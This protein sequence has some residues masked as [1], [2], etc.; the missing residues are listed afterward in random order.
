MPIADVV[1]RLPSVDRLTFTGA[2]G[3]AWFDD[4]CRGTYDVE[5]AHVAYQPYR[6]SLV[7]ES[8]D[9]DL[10]VSL[11]P[12]WYEVEQV[13]V[14]ADA[15]I[16]QVSV[17]R[18]GISVPRATLEEFSSMDMTDAVALLPGVTVAGNRPFYRGVGFEQVQP[19]VDGVPARVPLTGEWILP[20]PQALGSAELLS[21]AMIAD[22]PASLGGVLAFRL[23]EGGPEPRARLTVGADGVGQ[24][25]EGNRRADFGS[26]AASGPAGLAGLTYS[27]AWQG[28]V[29]NGPHS[30]DIGSPTQNAFGFIPLG[31]RMEGT[32]SGSMKLTWTDSE[33]ATKVST[34][35]I[36]THSRRKAY[37]HPYSRSGWVRYLANLDRYTTFLDNPAD[38]KGLFFYEGPE[39]VPLDERSS[40]LAFTTAR[41]AFASG[42]WVSAHLEIGRHD[43]H[44]QTEGPRIDDE[45]ALTEWVRSALTSPLHQEEPFYA[46]H[47]D[48]PEF[49]SGSSREVGGG[50]SGALQWGGAHKIG[51]GVN[52]TSGRHAYAWIAPPLAMGTFDRRLGVLETNAYLEDTWYSDKRS[53]MQL[54]LR[55]NGRRLSW[56]SRSWDAGRFA[57]AL[58]FHQPMTATDAMHVEAG[59]TYQ[60]PT[61]RG[62]F[63]RD[64]QTQGLQVETQRLRFAEVGVQHHFSREAVLYVGGY[65]REYTDVVFASQSPTEIEAAFGSPRRAPPDFIE[66][67]G[68]EAILDHQFHPRLV[69]QCSVVLSRAIQNDEMEVP[70][71]RRLA[72]RQ[73]L[74]WEAGG[75][76][77]AT[78]TQD[79]ST[80]RR[81]SVC[82]SPRGCADDQLRKGALPSLFE[83]DVALRWSRKWNGLAID[84]RAEVYNLFHRRIPTYD[85]SVYPALISAENFLAYYHDTGHTN[86]Y[87][88]EGNRPVY[89]EF[90][91]P[92][93]LTA[94]R[95]FIA[96]L[97]LRF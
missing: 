23:A 53:W 14:R 55:Y 21:G 1:V 50:A 20:P 94:G 88:V 92:E 63:P 67:R 65:L 81:Y 87:V 6:A 4:L 80:G 8:Q 62:Y 16:P 93:A 25:I 61:L 59:T 71:N 22:A 13:E 24:L 90:H 60:F 32:E 72:A 68:L 33:R 18:P 74:S 12:R 83:T 84:L 96:G 47:G 78:V 48:F 26:L 10:R 97:S 2:D 29:T 75:G 77:A 79:W 70:W 73:W 40:V 27:A 49:H 39:R 46:V 85:F 7:V 51:F 42:S 9:V 11:A 15:V 5:V 82:L 41:K 34:A 30:Y 58:A 69:G 3:R 43:M 54:A 19:I 35:V 52:V 95:S 28:R 86:G 17:E 76:W 31:R 89:V 66:A 91:D 45:A 56:G 37:R 44:V 57:P 36:G 64:P 38:T